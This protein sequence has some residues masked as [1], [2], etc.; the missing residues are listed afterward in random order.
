MNRTRL[1]VA[2]LVLALLTPGLAAQAPTA[3]ES[4]RISGWRIDTSA[5][6]ISFYVRARLTNVRGVFRSFGLREFSMSGDDLSSMRGK[7]AIQTATVFSRDSKRDEHLRQDDFFWSERYP[8]ALVTV[9]SIV[10]QE[11]RYMATFT[12]QIRDKSKSYTIPLEIVREGQ[13]IRATGSLQADRHHFD[14]NGTFGAN[15]VMDDLVDLNFRIVLT[16]G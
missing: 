6:Q 11:G 9:D 14:L 1:L 5:S 13:S 15:L 8:D 2:A 4:P 3:A 7:I 16:K 12:L 10:L